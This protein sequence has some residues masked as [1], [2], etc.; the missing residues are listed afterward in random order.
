MQYLKEESRQS[1][2]KEGQNYLPQPG[3]PLLFMQPRTQLAFWV[4]GAHCQAMANFSF[5]GTL[6]P[7]SA[8]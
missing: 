1:R 2:V 3:V 4:A 5:T 7:S 8:K 6:S